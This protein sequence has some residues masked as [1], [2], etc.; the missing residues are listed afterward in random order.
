MIDYWKNWGK[1]P[2]ENKNDD[3]DH[4][5]VMIKPGQRYEKDKYISYGVRNEDT[6]KIEATSSP[7]RVDESMIDDLIFAL[8]Y[9][10]EGAVVRG[11]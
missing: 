10:G 9:S 7:L 5:V 4:L 1:F 6:G 11:V 3:D 8:K 2:I